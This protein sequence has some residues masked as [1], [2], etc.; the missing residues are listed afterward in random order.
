MLKVYTLEQSEEWDDAVRKCPHYDVFYLSSYMKAYAMQGAGAPMLAVYTN[1]DDY[2]VNAVFIRDVADDRHFSGIIG[3]NIYF[4]ISSQ[5]GYGGF[6]GEVSNWEK[7]E[8]DWQDYLAG[9]KFICEFE[10]FSLFSD[11]YKY[12]SGEV[13]SHSHNV[14]RS[15]GESLDDIWMDFKQKVRKNVKKANKYEL[16]LIVENTGEYI[17][18]FLRIYYGTMDRAGADDTFYFD[19]SFFQ[20]LNKMADNICYFHVIYKNPETNEERIISTELVIYGSENAYSYLGGTDREYFD[21]RPNDF[22]KWEIIKW[23]KNKG[24]KHFVLGGGYGVDD[25]IFEYKKCL[26]PNGIVDFYIG[27][28]IYIQEKYD[29]LVSMR[30]E[31]DSSYFPKYRA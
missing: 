25:G 8:Q 22:L 2:A 29:E 17:D 9:Q 11:Y 15:L 26:A 1:G 13:E 14:V 10:R 5:Y 7:L 16:K 28:K 21:M 6:V 31:N 23:A 4:D 12:F 3:E 27:K 30:D 19:K 18:D 24:L 20:E